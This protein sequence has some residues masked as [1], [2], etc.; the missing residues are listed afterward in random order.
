[1]LTLSLGEVHRIFCKLEQGAQ[2]SKAALSQEVGFYL[3]W[4]LRS[5]R[6]LSGPWGNIPEV[7]D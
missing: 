5:E 4:Y 1:M 7:S 3:P 2:G 6:M